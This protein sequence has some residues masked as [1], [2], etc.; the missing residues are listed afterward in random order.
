MPV[1]VLGLLAFHV[2]SGLQ[3]FLYCPGHMTEAQ[4]ALLFREMET[5]VPTGRLRPGGSVSC[6]PV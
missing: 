4:V 5:G 2:S 1:G 3:L 6:F